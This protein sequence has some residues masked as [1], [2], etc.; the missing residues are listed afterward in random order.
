MK[1]IEKQLAIYGKSVGDEIDVQGGKYKIIAKG[2]TTLTIEPTSMVIS[3]NTYDF[4]NKKVYSTFI[5][6]GK[7]VTRECG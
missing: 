1:K 4:D 2:E 5:E 3:V 7:I 6:N